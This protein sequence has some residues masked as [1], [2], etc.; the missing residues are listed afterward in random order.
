VPATASVLVALAMSLF[1]QPP[2]G[3]P[4]SAADPI[5][6]LLAELR[7]LRIVME[8]TATVNPRIQLVTSRMSL[9]DER[10]YRLTRQ[11]ENLRDELERM[12]MESREHAVRTRRLED[13]LAN[14]TDQ[15]KRLQMEEQLRHMKSESEL[16]ATREQLLRTRETEAANTLAVEQAHWNELTRRLDELER[17]LE[18]PER[19]E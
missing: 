10:V 17:M 4:S 6:A 8:R 3:Q 13:V 14:E 16:W 9:Q 11:V 5:A 18:L 7:Q 19:R 15:T 12:T 2:G 1:F